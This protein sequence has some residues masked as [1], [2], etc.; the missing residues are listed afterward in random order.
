MKQGPLAGEVIPFLSNC[1]WLLG[2]HMGKADLSYVFVTG[3]DNA[4]TVEAVKNAQYEPGMPR[5][6]ASMVY[7]TFMQRPI[8]GGNVKNDFS[9]EMAKSRG[10]KVS[11]GH[12]VKHSLRKIWLSQRKIDEAFFDK[13]VNG[14]V[15]SKSGP[16]N[17]VPKDAQLMERFSE[18][19]R[20]NADKVD[21]TKKVNAQEVSATKNYLPSK[22]MPRNPSLKRDFGKVT[23]S[24]GKEARE[25]HHQFSQK[26]SG[27]SPDPKRPKWLLIGGNTCPICKAA[28]FEKGTGRHSNRYHEGRLH[29]SGHFMDEL[30]KIV[31]TWADPDTCQMCGHKT[32]GKN[33]GLDK[34]AKHL[35]VGHS[36]LDKLLQR[37][38][39][40]AAKKKAAEATKQSQ[41]TGK[42]VGTKEGKDAFARR[43]AEQREELKQESVTNPLRNKPVTSRHG[44]QMAIA[45]CVWPFRLLDYGSA[46]LRCKI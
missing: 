10:I 44:C 2:R 1:T 21:K 27:K 37:P 43:C 38:E 14:D 12:G 13:L 24:F 3:A 29:V 28:V 19:T 31:M 18:L 23:G 4:V 25:V 36:E 6:F 39:L 17:S 26:E 8:E 35:G 20:T 33:K 16:E 11:H 30:K 34:M 22:C 40:V 42:N 9:V 7:N 41:Q 15:A 46:T 5:Y 45:R 32:K